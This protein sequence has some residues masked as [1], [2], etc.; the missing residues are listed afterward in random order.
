M[1]IFKALIFPV[2]FFKETADKTKERNG[3]TNHI[4]TWYILADEVALYGI[5][6]APKKNIDKA[7]NMKLY[8]VIVFGFMIKNYTLI[9]L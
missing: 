6:N 4:S 8:K 9:I 5:P 2:D 7:S 3:N 1:I